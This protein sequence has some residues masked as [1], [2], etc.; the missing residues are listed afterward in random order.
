MALLF[1]SSRVQALRLSYDGPDM[2]TIEPMIMPLQ[3]VRK[4]PALH[5]VVCVMTSAAL[6]V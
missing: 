4:I 2:T 6:I 1:L 5:G 3:E